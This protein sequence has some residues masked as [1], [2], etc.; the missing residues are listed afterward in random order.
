MKQIPFPTLFFKKQA[1]VEN[2][3]CEQKKI[4]TNPVMENRIRTFVKNCN[5]FIRFY[6]FQIKYANLANTVTTN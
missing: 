5:V 4:F 3:K 6:M 1:F 2:R